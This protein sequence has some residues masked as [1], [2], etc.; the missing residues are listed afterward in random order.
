MRPPPDAELLRVVMVLTRRLGGSVVL[1]P[2]EAV[3]GGDL[4]M[5][6]KPDGSLH[7]DTSTDAEPKETLRL[8]KG[9]H[10]A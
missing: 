1:T 4:H 10:L 2:E 9:Y 6:T 8:P 7:I 5:A 3:V